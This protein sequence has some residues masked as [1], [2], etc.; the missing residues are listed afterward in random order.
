M[1]CVSI[2]ASSLK[3]LLTRYLFN[4]LES[5]CTPFFSEDIQ[6]LNPSRI[7]KLI[8]ERTFG[9]PEKKAIILAALKALS[10][11]MAIV[12]KNGTC[13]QIAALGNHLSDLMSLCR[14]RGADDTFCFCLR[15][16]FREVTAQTRMI[17]EDKELK[18]IAA[19]SYPAISH[20]RS[21]FYRGYAARK[22]NMHAEE[23]WLQKVVYTTK[24][25][26]YLR[27]M[28]EGNMIMGFHLF[29]RF[30]LDQALTAATTKD[31]P[32]SLLAQEMRLKAIKEK[33]DYH[34]LAAVMVMT[35]NM[36]AL[37]G[38]QTDKLSRLAVEGIHSKEAM[39]K[40]LRFCPNMA[41]FESHKDPSS[42]V[43]K[44]MEDEMMKMWT[45]PRLNKKNYEYIKDHLNLENPET[46]ASKLLLESMRR[47]GMGDGGMPEEER[48][49]NLADAGMFQLFC[50]GI[51]LVHG[52]IFT[53]IMSRAA[54]SMQ[55]D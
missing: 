36:Q 8:R 21:L 22:A 6:T 11:L 28:E 14:K 39:V 47:N 5:M 34:V 53:G 1:F 9:P 51:F 3:G 23:I 38:L 24:K 31:L 40:L 50:K 54:L 44:I 4:L 29:S 13:C 49:Q 45:F 30:V 52:K 18:S 27:E 33:F 19:A 7:R 32:V 25:Q 26:E 12:G 10:G 2:L 48:R 37:P 55:V 42:K 46:V 20:N 43:Y 15:D 16:V 17:L 41:M 35:A